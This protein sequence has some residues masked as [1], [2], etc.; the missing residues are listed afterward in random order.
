MPGY[1]MSGRLFLWHINMVKAIIR[2]VFH[3]AMQNIA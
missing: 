3:A 1:R 2:L